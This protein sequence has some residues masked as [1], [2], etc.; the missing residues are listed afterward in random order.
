MTSECSPQRSK[1]ACAWASCPRR[2][3]TSIRSWLSESI[4]SYGVIPVSRRETRATSI[5]IPLPPLLAH[6]TVEDVNPARPQ[7]LHGHQPGRLQHL[8]AGL[9]QQLLP[10]GVTHL[11]DA[12]VGGLGVV[13]A[14]EGRPVQAV[15]PGVRPHQEDAVPLPVAREETICSARAIPTHIALTRGFSE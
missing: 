3:T 13:H 4:T 12:P 10:E 9:D 1:T 7:V 14:G 2:T 5:S 6:S 15:P 11:D 8:Q